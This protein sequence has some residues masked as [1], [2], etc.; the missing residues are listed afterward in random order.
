[1]RRTFL[2]RQVT[3]ATPV[4]RVSPQKSRTHYRSQDVYA[5]SSDQPGPV[6]VIHD[7]S[8]LAVIAFGSSLCVN[9][10]LA[11]KAFEG[12]R[13]A[14]G[15]SHQGWFWWGAKRRNDV[16]RRDSGPWQRISLPSAH[17]PEHRCRQ[18]EVWI[19]RKLQN[20]QYRVDVYIFRGQDDQ[21]H[22]IAPER[23]NLDSTGAHQILH[24]E[25][26]YLN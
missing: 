6:L 4:S 18:P 1:M 3:Q 21:Q 16:I 22:S 15:Q 23:N 7:C 24:Y 9:S 26:L 2:A 20:K 13:R 5:A 8:S 17:I 10:A 12:H 14:F 19:E 25:A 11:C